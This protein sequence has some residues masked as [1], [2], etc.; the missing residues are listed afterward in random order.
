VRKF[1]GCAT[2]RP[3][4]YARSHRRLPRFLFQAT[5]QPNI[6]TLPHIIPQKLHT[7]ML[8]WLSALKRPFSSPLLSLGFTLRLGLEFERSKV[9]RQTDV[10]ATGTAA[11]QFS[12][13]S[14]WP[15]HQCEVSFTDPLVW[16][17]GTLTRSGNCVA[18]VAQT[19]TK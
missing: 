6:L 19:S 5:K 10:T 16:D 11:G 3:F 1:D 18:T 13:R 2:A 14:D 17:T 8:G 9:N 15:P 7:K 4:R 12:K